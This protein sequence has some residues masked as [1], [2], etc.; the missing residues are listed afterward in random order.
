MDLGG[1]RVLLVAEA[2]AMLDRVGSYLSKAG[3]RP[4][5]ALRA[6]GLVAVADCCDVIVLFDDYGEPEEFNVFLEIL[7]RSRAPLLIVTERKDLTRHAVRAEI[8]PAPSRL[9]RGWS[10]LHAI[11]NEDAPGHPSGAR[12]F[13]PRVAL[14]GLSSRAWRCS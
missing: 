13:D 11:R 9:V 2:P 1:T 4:I 8:L 3:A 7:R 6:T 14:H 10:L 12:G 5:V